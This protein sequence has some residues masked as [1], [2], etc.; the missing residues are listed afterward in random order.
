MI[1]LFCVYLVYSLIKLKTIPSSISQLYYQIDPK[2]VFQVLLVGVGL[3]LIPIW[4]PITDLTCFPFLSCAAMIFI[5][6]SPNLHIKLEYNIHM[7]AAYICCISAIMWQVLIGQWIILLVVGLLCFI[8]FLFKKQYVWWIE[9]WT[10]L[11]TILT[12]FI[13]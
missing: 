11:S 1:T 4:L 13:L 6:V 3:E 5:G 2:W 7:A 9:I 12:I 8:G 10:M